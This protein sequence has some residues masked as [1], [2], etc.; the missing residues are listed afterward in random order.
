MKGKERAVLKSTGYNS[1]RII[2][3]KGTRSHSLYSHNNYYYYNSLA[4]YKSCMFSSAYNNYYY[5]DCS[6]NTSFIST[7]HV[8]SAYTYQ[9]DVRDNNVC[10]QCFL[11]CTLCTR[12]HSH[13]HHVVLHSWVRVGSMRNF[14]IVYYNNVLK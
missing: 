13:L 10:I 5:Y 6:D 2:Y 9:N 7:N 3:T 11:A 8:H 1:S 12:H 14:M 4:R